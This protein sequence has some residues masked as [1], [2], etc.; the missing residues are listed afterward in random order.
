MKTEKESPLLERGDKPDGVKEDCAV[1]YPV[2]EK[3][4][5]QKRSTR[6]WSKLKK[7]MEKKFK[8]NPSHFKNLNKMELPFNGKALIDRSR[9]NHKLHIN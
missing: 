7:Y 5:L 8:E 6:L 4:K 1:D 9:I 3:L 2:E